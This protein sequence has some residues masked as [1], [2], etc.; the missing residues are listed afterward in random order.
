MAEF[1]DARWTWAQS[2]AYKQTAS[3]TWLNIMQTGMRK[4]RQE[5][6]KLG[7]QNTRYNK[8][9]TIMRPKAKTFSR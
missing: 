4:T 1:K 2:K 7:Y 9:R 3:N 6:D 8:A 5:R